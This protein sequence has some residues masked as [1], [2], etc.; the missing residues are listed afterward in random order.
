[1]TSDIPSDIHEQR[2]WHFDNC[3]GS[4][5]CETCNLCVGWRCPKFHQIWTIFSLSLLLLLLSLTSLPTLKT[6]QDFRFEA[7]HALVSAFF[8]R[9]R[10]EWEIF[11]HLAH[12]IPGL[13]YLLNLNSFTNAKWL[14]FRCFS[15]Y[16][17]TFY[18]A[19]STRTALRGLDC[20]IRP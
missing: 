6:Q 7:V 17:V 19:N 20:L 2:Q 18:R 13:Q 1:M 4:G 3:A 16:F 9:L 12:E 14:G 10:N 8:T 5:G 15:C 11:Y